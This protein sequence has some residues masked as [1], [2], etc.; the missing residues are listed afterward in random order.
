MFTTLRNS[1][2]RLVLPIVWGR[3]SDH[4][5]RT[6]KRFG[7]TESDSGWQYLQAI[8]HTDDDALKRMLFSN[9]LEEYRHS[10]YFYGAAHQLASSRLHSPPCARTRLVKA[11]SDMAY[12]LAY[13]HEC[14]HSIHGQFDAFASACHLPAVSDVF[15]R[16][17]ADEED[18]EAQAHDFLLQAVGGEK[19][20][21][22]N[23]VFK[24]KRARLYEAWMRGSQRMGDVTF[25]TLLS[26]VFFAFGPLVASRR[27]AAE[28]PPQPLATARA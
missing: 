20:R 22:R 18:H 14:E 5:A 6:L 4:A 13:A 23:M 19:S 7:D 11:P 9:V 27:R 15:R 16:I 10:D 1:I 25:G 28:P 2:T 17:C 8:E 26:I 21:A 24:A 12:F 3:S